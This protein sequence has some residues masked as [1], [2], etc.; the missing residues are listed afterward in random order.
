MSWR[1]FFRR[2][3]WDEERGRELASYLETETEENVARGMTREEAKRAAH[4]KLGNATRIREEIYEMNSLS[5]LETLGQDLRYGARMLRKNP[6]F[7]AIA[8]LTLALGIGANTAIFSV[9]DSVLLRPLPYKDSNSL[10]ILWENDTRHSNPHNTIAPPDF[11]DWQSQNT[12]FADMAGFV[13]ER[14]NFTGNGEPE[15][16]VVQLVTPNFFSVLGV[17]PIMGSGFTAENG[18]A[19]HTNVVILAYGFWKERFGGDPGIIGK[20]ILLNGHSQTVVGVAPRDFEWFIKDGSLTGAKPQ[21][22]GPWVLPQRFRDRKQIGRFM[23]AVAR[24]KRGVSLRQ[25]QT[26]M[27]TIVTRLAQ[28]YPD[29]NQNWGISVVPLREQLSGNLR[30]ALLILLGAVVFVLLIACA[31]VSSLLLARAASRERELAIRTAIGASRSRIA[32]QLLT[33]SALLTAAGGGLGVLLAFLGTNILL[34]SSPQNLLDVNSVSINFRILLFAATATVLTGFLFGFLPSYISAHQRISETLKEGGRTS[35][36]AKGRQFARRAFVVMQMALSVVLLVG[37]GLLIRSFARLAGVDP[38]F[39]ASHMITFRVTLPESKYGTDQLQMD[40]FKQLVDRI[41]RLPG[42]RSVSMSSCPPFSGLGAATDVH[43]LSQPDVPTERPVAAVRVVGPNYFRTMEIPLRAGRTFN[44]AELATKRRVVI[45]NQAFANMFLRGK[46]PLGEK[47]SIFMRGGD[48]DTKFPSQIIGV[49]G[50]V[51]QMALD[52]PAEPTVYWPHPELVYSEMT[53]VART[54]NDPLALVSAARAEVQRMDP[55][56]PISA[57][58][59]MDQLLGDSVSLSRFTTL[60]L[61]VFAAM[62]LV[63]AAVGIYGVIAYAVAQRTHEIGIRMALGAR[64]Y[65]VLR[66][67]LGQGTRLTL[68]GAG[69]G[70]IAALALTRLMTSLLYQVSATDPLTFAAVA[71]LLVGVALAASYVPA[72]RATKVDPLVA[73]RYE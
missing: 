22:W 42:V 4:V 63:L 54:S 51:R 2:R 58:A 24:I 13:D 69:I 41:G 68:L 21:M 38:G 52:T 23:T 47:V 12:V 14:D 3:K 31:N 70:V 6:G 49:V 66:L 71:L 73:L 26:E 32:R 72:R 16:V 37:A 10:V 11:L 15:Q 43:I 62:A 55:N 57:V 39:N 27:N 36:S 33:E 34:A 8:I 17:N 25:A 1:R 45:V 44:D 50:D 5:F 9:I 60:V 7:S 35:S 48:E 56:Q 30:P 46:N 53:I 29:F 19:A 28:E 40:F 64:P 18:Q 61:G 67:V 59:T 20:T 65:D